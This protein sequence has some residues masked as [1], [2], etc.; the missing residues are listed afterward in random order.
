[1]T[2]AGSHVVVVADIHA[3]YGALSAVLHHAA[4]VYGSEAQLLQLGDL[5]NYGPRANDV[6]ATIRT[7]TE[8][9]RVAVSL[10]GNHEAALQGIES[11]RFSTERGRLALQVAADAILPEHATFLRS[12]LRY[13]PVAVE[14]AGRRVLCVHGTVPDHFWGSLRADEVRSDVYRQYDLVF[15]AHT[16]I[17]LFYETFYADPSSPKRGRKKTTFL[18]PGSVGQPRNHDPRAQYLVWDTAT[19][20]FH[21]HKVPYDVAAEQSYFSDK[22]D[23]FYKTRLAEGV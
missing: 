6:V 23:S 13:E 19:E 4:G 5:I 21:F 8:G 20:T 22:V 18:N 3:N 12:E 17:P 7:L 14:I 2:D 1:L 11:D 10:A 9:G 15:C 16:H